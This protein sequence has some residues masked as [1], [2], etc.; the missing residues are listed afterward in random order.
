MQKVEAFIGAQCSA[1]FLQETRNIKAGKAEMAF[2]VNFKGNF[3]F[4][5]ALKVKADKGSNI[6]DSGGFKELHEILMD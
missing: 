4:N 3:M 6:K 1:R 5:Q 2:K